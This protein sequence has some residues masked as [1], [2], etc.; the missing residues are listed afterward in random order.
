MNT[1]SPPLRVTAALT[2]GE[3]SRLRVHVT[4]FVHIGKESH[5]LEEVQQGL[6][7]PETTYVHY[8]NE[9]AEWERDKQILRTVPRRL[10]AKWTGLHVRSVKA[11]LNTKRLP[12]R[13]HRR[14]LHEIA[15]KLRRRDSGLLNTIPAEVRLRPGGQN[16][17]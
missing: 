5:E 17:L 9:R 10:L 2:T 14:I 1:N 4:G 11:I 12:H 7:P 3:L 6:V 13:G 8:V 15:E 16:D